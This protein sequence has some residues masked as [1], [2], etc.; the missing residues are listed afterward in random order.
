M[1]VLITGISRGI[2]YALASEYLK[3]GD[4]VYA[5]GRSNPFDG[6]K[7]QKV[8]MAEIEKFAAAIDKLKIDTLNVAVLN[9]GIL[10]EIKE[11]REWSVKELRDI[12]E[13]NVWA[14]K[15]LID[16]LAPFTKKIVL[17]SSGAAVNG[18][19]GWGGYSLSKCALNMM[20]KIY[21]QEINSKI[22]A[23]A[24]GVIET[25][26]VNKVINADKNK[27]QS[28]QRVDESK[29]PLNEGAKRVAEAIDKL[30]AFPSGSFVD[31]RKI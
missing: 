4:S 5:L 22:Y 30:D 16:I 25:D 21:S 7:F 15:V 27:F 9:A 18:N 2:G 29:I 11:M 20:A 8:D 23:L 17:I 3:R 31:V 28:V 13:I 14:N 26:M 12:F 10:G 1:K 6:V 24:P 19:K